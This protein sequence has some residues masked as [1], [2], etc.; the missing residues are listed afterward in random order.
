M[1]GRAL[2]YGRDWG[3]GDEVHVSTPTDEEPWW[4]IKLKGR[5]ED[6]PWFEVRC[7]EAAVVYEN[8]K[9]VEIYY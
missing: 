8:G 2:F 7:S 9:V 3:D 1:L 4:E 5:D 6:E